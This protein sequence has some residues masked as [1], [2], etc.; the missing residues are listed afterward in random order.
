[1]KDGQRS[2]KTGQ[3][4]F[5]G[6]DAA[7][8]W[9]YSVAEPLESFMRIRRTRTLALLFLLLA[10]FAAT[11]ARS[12]RSPAKAPPEAPAIPAA[13]DYTDFET[14]LQQHLA[15]L[16]S[17]DIKAYAATITR[18]ETLYLVLPDGKLIPTRFGVIDYYRKWFADPS[19]RM[20]F[21]RLRTLVGKDSAVVFFH[22]VYDGNG[23]NGEPAHSEGYLTLTFRH[24]P[25]GW[26][27][28]HEQNTRIAL[29]SK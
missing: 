19:W 11:A 13:I 15:A 24:E 6:N 10:P 16:Q 7:A 12:P 9:R 23:N 2:A 18:S 1:M 25:Q 3:R 28:V 26:A 8:K 17:R 20:R 5:C 22:T 21:E 4:E 14:L 27:L 29:P